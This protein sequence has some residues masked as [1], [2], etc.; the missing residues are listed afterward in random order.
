VL[1]EDGWN[2]VVER[3]DRLRFVTADAG[4][5]F[6]EVARYQA[7]PSVEA[8]RASIATDQGLIDVRFDPEA[9]HVST[10]IPTEFCAGYE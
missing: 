2:I 8:G 3:R 4:C 9:M 10:R 7:S 6:S 5:L 1:G